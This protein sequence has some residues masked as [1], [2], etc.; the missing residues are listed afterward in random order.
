MTLNSQNLVHKMKN[1]AKKVRSGTIPDNDFD[2]FVEVEW[3]QLESVKDP[4]EGP[5][6]IVREDDDLQTTG[7]EGLVKH[8]LLDQIVQGLVLA[9]LPVKNFLKEF[10]VESHTHPQSCFG[11]GVPGRS[12]VS[13]FTLQVMCHLLM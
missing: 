3:L 4:W 12:R 13:W 1:F 9:F 5:L 7:E 2:D 8:C 6:R 11:E 10:V